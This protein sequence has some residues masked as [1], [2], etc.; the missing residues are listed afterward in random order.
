M[1]RFN[2]K[3]EFEMGSANPRINHW[4]QSPPTMR[5]N[6]QLRDHLRHKGEFDNCGR[7]INSKGIVTNRLGRDGHLSDSD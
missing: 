1:E 2:G 3:F 5:Y 7:L 4:A 6:G